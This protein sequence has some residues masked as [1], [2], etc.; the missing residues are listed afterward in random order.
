MDL[1]GSIYRQRIITD[2][3]YTLGLSFGNRTA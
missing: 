1:H 2:F 3:I